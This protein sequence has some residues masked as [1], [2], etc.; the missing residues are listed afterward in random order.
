MLTSQRLDGNIGLNK[1]ER[2][3]A[4]VLLKMAD[5]SHV[6]K[7]MLT[8]TMN[9]NITRVGG[10]LPFQMFTCTQTHV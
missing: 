9:I 4:S 6:G 3:N 2:E 1:I 8:P 10:A 7:M 5:R